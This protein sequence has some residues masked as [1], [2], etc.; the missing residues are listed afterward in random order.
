MINRI[1]H[2]EGKDF[3]PNE[4]LQHPHVVNGSVNRELEK[5]NFPK[6]LPSTNG[7]VIE[8]WLENMEMCFTLHDYSSNMKVCMVVFQLKWSVLLLWKTF[9]LS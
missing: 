6:F 7:L 9:F 4:G 3:V 2:D 8:A 5:V 1:D